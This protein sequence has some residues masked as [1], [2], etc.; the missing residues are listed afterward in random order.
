MAHKHEIRK[1][2]PHS[3]N[4]SRRRFIKS[5]AA[6]AA[7]TQAKLALPAS[8]IRP[9]LANAEA[10]SASQCLD[11]GWEY[12]RGALDGPWE[13]W[14][15]DEIA[16][17]EKVSLPHCFNDYDAC[18]PDTPYYRGHG[19]YR[20]HL[21][22]ANPIKDG[23]TL[24]YFEGAGQT[25]HVYVGGTMAGSHVGGYDEFVFDITDE[26]AAAPAS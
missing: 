6:V 23:R 11:S 3:F 10:C 9:V 13:V 25:S 1:P 12:Y 15:G 18:D 17:W 19:W 14:R 7:A 5:M 4:F 2:M 24:L 8:L 16:V 20:T 21:P 22:I 26:V